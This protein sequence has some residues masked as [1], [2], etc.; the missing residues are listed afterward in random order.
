MS[1]SAM[2]P[3]ALSSSSSE[4]KINTLLYSDQVPSSL[5]GR[6]YHYAVDGKPFFGASNRNEPSSP[7]SIDP[8]AACTNSFIADQQALLK[9]DNPPPKR[10]TSKKRKQGG[11]RSTTGLSWAETRQILSGSKRLKHQGFALNRFITLVPPLSIPED[12]ERKRW[13]D[14]RYSAIRTKMIRHGLPMIALRVFEK[15]VD[16]L[17]HLHMFV[18]LPRR[19]ETLLDNFNRRP[20]MMVLPTAPEHLTYVVKQR[21]PLSPEMESEVRKS[22]RRRPGAPF[23]GKRWGFSVDAEAIIG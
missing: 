11:W 13:C 22:L 19:H 21:L 15:E 17:L 18:H 20:E 8:G 6:N 9:G 12:S 4:S 23:P 1:G 10:I 7:L 5:E 14:R 3:S 2:S 16:G